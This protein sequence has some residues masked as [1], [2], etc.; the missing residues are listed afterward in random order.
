MAV[1]KTEDVVLISLNG[2]Q[3]FWWNMRGDLSSFPQSNLLPKDKKM[4][5]APDGSRM[6]TDER[7]LASGMY[8]ARITSKLLKVIIYLNKTARKATPKHTRIKEMRMRK[9]IFVASGAFVSS[10]PST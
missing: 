3:N 7:H 10:T 2:L 6:P 9:H 1:S 5:K 8:S 4:Y